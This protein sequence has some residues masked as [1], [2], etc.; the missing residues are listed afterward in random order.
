VSDFLNRERPSELK[1][2]LR[3][4]RLLMMVVLPPPKVVVH[5]LLGAI[6]A[7]PACQFSELEKP[8]LPP[9]HKYVRPV[10]GDASTAKRANRRRTAAMLEKRP[11]F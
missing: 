2:T 6:G 7:N 4:A 9:F 1:G 8:M 3:T 5:G 10:A 11:A